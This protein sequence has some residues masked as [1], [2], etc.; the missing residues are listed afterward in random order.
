MVSP[1]LSEIHNKVENDLERHLISMLGL[2]TYTHVN[3][4]LDALVSH[5]HEYAYMYI[6][7]THTYAEQMNNK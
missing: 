4:D 5:L 1:R 2:H 3:M 7:I 6:L